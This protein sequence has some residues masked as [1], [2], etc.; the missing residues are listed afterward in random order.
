MCPVVS[1][2]ETFFATIGSLVPVYFEGSRF[3]NDT[4]NEGLFS[5]GTAKM[6][7]AREKWRHLYVTFTQE[8]MSIHGGAVF[9]I[10][11]FLLMVLVLCF[12]V[13]L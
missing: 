6:C 4:H 3:F 9:V 13:V 7:D 11:F 1:Q 8:H 5:Y 10:A 12:G 2:N